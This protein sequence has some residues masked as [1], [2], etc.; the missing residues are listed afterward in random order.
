M[1]IEVNKEVP[2]AIQLDATDGLPPD[3][4]IRIVG[5][6]DGAMLTEGHRVSE[7]TWA[8]PL[9]RL[10]RLRLKIS[11]TL[12]ATRI[13]KVLLV[14][15]DGRVHAESAITLMAPPKPVI[16]PKPVTPAQK[17]ASQARQRAADVMRATSRLSVGNTTPPSSLGNPP[18]NTTT[19]AKLTPTRPAPLPPAAKP[20]PQSPQQL[21]AGRFLKRGNSFLLEGDVNAA[22]Q[23]YRRAADIGSALAAMAMA[24]TY[25]P[26]ELTSLGILDL[27]ADV[28]EAR[29]WY[30]KAKTLG[31]ASAQARIDRLAAQ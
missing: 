28:E 16:P 31:A 18:Q 1:L 4:F 3:S 2:V 6:P 5:L 17:Q 22:R 9:A 25:D 13:L 20:P 27:P 21:R 12:D 23:F 19:T 7:R 11:Q 14:S 15:L 8:V 24:S 26:N 29:K 30:E 10:M